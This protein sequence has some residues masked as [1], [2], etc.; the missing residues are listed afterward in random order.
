MKLLLVTIAYNSE[1][2]DLIY[3]SIPKNEDIEWH[4][5]CQNENI[6]NWTYYKEDRKIKTH[7]FNNKLTNTEKLNFLFEE[8]LSRKEGYVFILDNDNLFIP[9]TYSIYQNIKG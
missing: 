6:F 4:I 7:N 1:W 8:H 9:N 3:E 5:I 2:L